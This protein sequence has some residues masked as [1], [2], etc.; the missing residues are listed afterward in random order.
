MPAQY[1]FAHKDWTGAEEARQLQRVSDFC[2]RFAYLLDGMKV[3]DKAKGTIW[4]SLQA[5]LVQMERHY[6]EHTANTVKK[7]DLPG[8]PV[9]NRNEQ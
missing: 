5:L 6:Q 9:S 1:V 4:P 3:T 2:R 7:F 8:W